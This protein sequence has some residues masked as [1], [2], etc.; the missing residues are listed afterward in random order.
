MFSTSF[1]AFD[2]DNDRVLIR[3]DETCDFIK[4]T[5]PS[6][7]YERVGAENRVA[8]IVIETWKQEIR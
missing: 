6:V 8:L 3:K 2:D 5:N 7:H 1:L 4:W